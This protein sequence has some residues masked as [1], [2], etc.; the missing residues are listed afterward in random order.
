MCMADSS[1][2]VDIDSVEMGEKYICINCNTKFRGIGQRIHCP[3]CNSMQV[4]KDI[5]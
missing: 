1:I 5:D 3:T 4:E 2:S